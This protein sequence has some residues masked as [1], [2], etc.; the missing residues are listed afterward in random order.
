MVE[1]ISGSPAPAGLVEKVKGILLKPKEEWPKIAADP[2]TPGDI[3]TRYA[4]PLIAIGPIASFIGGQIFGYGAF[5]FSYRPSLVA[6]LTGAVVQFVTALVAL[7]VIT[8]VAEFLAPK[9]G[10][11]ANRR[12]AFKWV[13]FSCTAAWVGGVFGLIPGLALLG[14]LLG[15]YSLYLLYLGAT[16]VMK[17]P[18]DK[19]IGF[20]AVT[21]V[22]GI[23]LFWVASA[24]TAAVTAAVV[25]TA[26]FGSSIAD[27][28]GDLS[29]SVTIP[30]IGTV[31]ADK[32]EETSH[33]MEQMAKGE[34]QPVKPAQLSPLLP[35]SIGSYAR[36]ATSSTSAGMGSQATATYQ[37]G[38]RRFDLRVV[39]MAA[40]GGLAGMASAMGIEHSEED[41]DGYERVF[42]D[43]DHMV[44]EK[45]SK[46]GSNGS[47]GVVVGDRFMI[48]AEGQA[49]SIDELKAAVATVDQGDLE[50]LAG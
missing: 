37:A 50:D 34:I 18:E 42:K 39:D 36:V 10:G 48:E 27:R 12:Q 1:G 22:A 20:T 13:A 26:A 44:T 21:V 31:D 8:L 15:L 5:G 19:A 14:S 40:I 24:I 11:E 17:V 30:G 9:F 4:L 6:G 7:V 38:D 29:G 43:G 2:S 47:Y 25:G 3:A 23:V 33:R 28:S 32:I 49:A 41:A 46:S 45:W 35:A 16:P